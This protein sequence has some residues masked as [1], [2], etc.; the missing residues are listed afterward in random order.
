ME[1]HRT[2]QQGKGK[3]TETTTRKK[4][5]KQTKN[6]PKTKTT[7]SLGAFLCVFFSSLSLSF[8]LPLSPLLCVLAVL[9]TFPFPSPLARLKRLVSIRPHKTNKLTKQ[10][11]LF[12][13]EPVALL[14]TQ[15]QSHIHPLLS[16]S[17]SFSVVR[18]CN[19]HQRIKPIQT[20]AA[21]Q[22]TN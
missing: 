15:L 22:P 13:F 6:H 10:R 21:Q 3:R 1:Q 17:L 19:R 14:S 8:S 18:L 12:C 20:L 16:L 4:T 2:N 5:K 7:H 9:R 11:C